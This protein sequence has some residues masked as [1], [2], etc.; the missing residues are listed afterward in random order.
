MNTRSAPSPRHILLNGVLTGISA[1]FL[2]AFL[3]LKATLLTHSFTERSLVEIGVE[4]VTIPMLITV[5]FFASVGAL[6]ALVIA[7][8]MRLLGLHGTRIARS[9]PVALILLSSLLYAERLMKYISRNTDVEDPSAGLVGSILLAG[10]FFALFFVL[11]RILLPGREGV[12]RGDGRRRAWWVLYAGLVCA[13]AVSLLYGVEI[14]PMRPMEEGKALSGESGARRFSVL[15]ITIDTLRRDYLGCYGEETIHTPYIDRIAE[16]GARFDNAYSTAPMTLP[17]HASLFTGKLPHRHGVRS[18]SRW[19][20]L[21][22]SHITLAEILRENGFRTAAFVGARIINKNSGL[23]Q[24]FDHYGDIFDHM[25]YRVYRKGGSLVPRLLIACKLTDR[26][27]VVVRDA[28][29][30]TRNALAWLE[31]N[32]RGNFFLWVHYFDAH[33]PYTAD[34]QFLEMYAAP[35]RGE[36]GDGNS[37]EW[38][39]AHYKAGISQVDSQIGCL[40]EFL[41][42]SGRADSTLIIVVSDHGESFG[43][44]GYEGH[45][46]RIYEQT[47]RI[48]LIMRLPGMIAPGTVIGDLVSAADIAPTVLD[49]LSI[50]RDS[51]FEGQSFA[52]LV[53]K[54]PG[55]KEDFVFFETLRAFEEREFLFGMRDAH[56]KLILSIPDSLPELYSLDRD[57]AEQVNLAAS[58]SVRADSLKSVL[59][60]VLGPECIPEGAGSGEIGRELKEELRELGYIQ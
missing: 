54:E 32:G 29:E 27:N 41:E 25:W 36:R 9:A 2:V 34:P 15:F 38:K 13:S 57:P 23:D 30:V 12:S 16:G 33:P 40:V 45:A 49:I 55:V 14:F 19:N 21:A 8:I 56:W 42:E 60:R 18:N 43:E 39:K 51:V 26:S 53:R 20:V 5:S 59:A 47:V 10:V 22:P 1:G 28:F 11:E 7:W 35:A 4:N 44:H 58:L 46:F 6:A 24:G 31:E 37:L 52:S 48:P 17:S 50:R 3:E